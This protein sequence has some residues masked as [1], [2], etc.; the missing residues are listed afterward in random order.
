MH[1]HEHA[2]FFGAVILHSLEEL[3]TVL[4][5]LFLAYLFM[6]FLEHRA[7]ERME[8]A[9]RRAGRIGPLWGSL[10]G[11]V[12]QCGFS[13][14][15]SGLYSG[16][17]ITLGT[18]LAVFLSTSDEMLPLMIGQVSP[19]R[20]LKILGVKVLIALIAG[21]AVDGV[22]RL[23]HK[24]KEHH[25][26]HEHHHEHNH[27]H[28]H[29]HHHEHHHEH[30]HE[31]HH[32]HHHDHEHEHRGAFAIREMCESDGCKCERGI[33]LSSLYHTAK[34]G[35]F[36]LAVV[37]LLNLA[38]FFIGEDGLAGALTAVPFL[39]HLLCSLVGLIPN[40]AASVVITELYLEGII[41]AGCMLSGLLV[42]AGIGLLLL[43]RVSRKKRDAFIVLGLLFAI[44]LLSGILVDVSGLGAL[45]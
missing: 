15:A 36:L 22:I 34:T 12:P 26:D 41:S 8:N 6:E 44:G 17:V 30:D 5:F 40:C 25:H 23:L 28:D 43:F 1:S 33:W 14:A 7:G 21:F 27:E 24:K 18:L 29:E 39:S 19:L 42:S 35:G 31:H 4:P 16:G 11:I 20:I 3:L 45:L 10:L 2:G 13:A 38:V 9:V 37:L 32:E